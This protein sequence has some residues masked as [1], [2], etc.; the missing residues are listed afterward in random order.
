MAKTAVLITPCG[1]TAA[2]MLFLPPS[3]T[4]IVMNYWLTYSNVSYQIDAFVR[5]VHVPHSCF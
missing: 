2:G 4:A 3:S 5:P 1:G